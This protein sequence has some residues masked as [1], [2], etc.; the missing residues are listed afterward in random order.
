M[1]LGWLKAFGKWAAPIAGDLVRDWWQRRQAKKA[2]PP[3]PA[4]PAPAPPAPIEDEDDG[5]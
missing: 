2:A 5:A 4:P 3:A 1:T